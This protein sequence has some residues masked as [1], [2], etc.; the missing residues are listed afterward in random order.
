MNPTVTPSHFNETDRWR[1]LYNMLLG[2]LPRGVVANETEPPHFSGYDRHVLYDWDQYFETIVQLYAGY[3]SYYARNGVDR[4]LRFQTE[5]GRVPRTLN[6]KDQTRPKHWDMAKPFLAQT[7]LLIEQADGTEGETPETLLVALEKALAFWDG[8]E[9][10][11]RGEGLSV[12]SFCGQMMDGL[13]ERGGYHGEE[14][15][16]SEAV[17]LNAYLVREARCLAQLAENKGQVARAGGWRDWAD[18]KAEAMNRWLWNEEDGIYYDYHAREKR[19]IPVKCVSAF[20]P[21]WAGVADSRQAD[22]LVREHLMNEAEFWRPWPLPALAADEPGYVVGRWRENEI[23][24]S[25]RAHTWAPT[26]YMTMHGLVRYGFC[27]EAAAL[28]RKSAELFSKQPFQEYWSTESG[29]GTGIK[30]FW[31]WSALFL[32]A[33]MELEHGA[34]PTRVEARN[35]SIDLILKAVRGSLR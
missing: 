17:D 25:W 34:D 5:E 4:F 27:E 15:H 2:Y 22:R 13:W 14:D 3:P 8:P 26:N 35:D 7:L 18:R 19:P 20:T 16:F 12:M 29:Q 28:A 21:L 10:N 33:E 6:K 32:F 31:G 23:G 1:S 11:P 30:P 9:C 24:C